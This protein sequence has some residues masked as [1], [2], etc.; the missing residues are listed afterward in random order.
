MTR[1]NPSTD[2]TATDQFAQQVENPSLGPHVDE[3][4]ITES[5]TTKDSTYLEAVPPVVVTIPVAG[6]KRDP[7]TEPLQYTAWDTVVKAFDLGQTPL[8]ISAANPRDPSQ[9]GVYHDIKD[10]VE[11]DPQ[12]LRLKNNGITIVASRVEIVEEDG[13]LYAVFLFT[14]NEGVVNGGHT[15]LAISDVAREASVDKVASLRLEVITSKQLTQDQLITTAT[16]RNEGDSH[17]PR[18][19]INHQG[20]FEPLKH[21]L[22]DPRLVDWYEGDSDHYNGALQSQKFVALLYALDPVKRSSIYSDID[23]DHR[24]AASGSTSPLTQYKR[25]AERWS[26][27]ESSEEL[28]I[29]DD[30][31]IVCESPQPWAHLY[32]LLPFV[33]ALR[34]GLGIVLTETSKDDPDHIRLADHST[35]N[36]QFWQQHIKSRDDTVPMRKSIHPRWNGETAVDVNRVI[37]TTVLGWLRKNI[38]MPGNCSSHIMGWRRDPLALLDAKKIDWLNEISE[39][40]DWKANTI[41][42]LASDARW[43][44]MDKQLPGEIRPRNPDIIRRRHDPPQ[45]CYVRVDPFDWDNNYPGKDYTSNVQFLVEEADTGV[46]IEPTHVLTDGSLNPEKTPE[47]GQ[48]AYSR[49][50]WFTN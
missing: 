47:Y 7:V 34:D 14:E 36:C 8:P 10:T 24:A 4:R 22:S 44:A 26:Q 11:D 37:E 50:N 32:P 42:S 25:A 3:A 43:Y 38:W 29:N 17:E 5:Q 20:Y 27:V 46:D 12:N 35:R 9:T 16:T 33:L 18:S 40:K 28:D 41:R 1:Q 15:T 6:A 45:I 30:A 13:Q 39:E 2:Q 31:E 21:N 19:L 23:S 48:T 49:V